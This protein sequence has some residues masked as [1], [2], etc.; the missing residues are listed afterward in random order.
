MEQVSG[1]FDSEGSIQPPALRPVDDT[2]ARPLPVDS[3]GWA[4]RPRAPDSTPRGSHGGAPGRRRRRGR[5]PDLPPRQASRNLAS[6]AEARRPPRPANARDR[7]A[8][9]NPGPAHRRSTGRALAPRHRPGRIGHGEG[10]S[11]Q[12][13][14]EHVPEHPSDRRGASSTWTTPIRRHQMGLR[15]RSFRVATTARSRS[16]VREPPGG[17]AAASTAS[18]HGVGKPAPATPARLRVASATAALPLGWAVGWTTGPGRI[19]RPGRAPRWSCPRG[20][21]AAEVG[22]RPEPAGEGPADVTG[23]LHAVPRNGIDH[24]GHPWL[25]EPGHRSVRAGRP[26]R[27]WAHCRRRH[28]PRRWAALRTSAASRVREAAAPATVLAGAGRARPGR[29]P[30]VQRPGGRWPGALRHGPGGA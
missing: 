28:R 11:P 18:A 24:H 29:R 1:V 14:Q 6:T 17:S 2:P 12:T 25:I 13:P 20:A 26:Q 9:A 21:V 3:S 19:A 16:S 22:G 23:C 30:F 27:P 7:A 5:D 15:P 8:T 4:S 10:Q